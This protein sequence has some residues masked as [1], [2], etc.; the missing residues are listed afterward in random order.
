MRPKRVKLTGEAG[1]IATGATSLLFTSD[2]SKLIVGA[3]MGSSLVMVVDLKG[4][5]NDNP[6]VLRS[7]EQH[8]MRSVIIG[9]I[10]RAVKNLPASLDAS[11]GS[12]HHSGDDFLEEPSERL[13]LH[14]SNAPSVTSTITCMATS[15]DGQ[16]LA[17]GDTR[18][19]IHVFNL[20]SVQV[21]IRSFYVFFPFKSFPS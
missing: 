9:G 21:F 7:F 6:R 8:R 16:W 3:C 13:N 2:S 14:S 11:E 10:G 12:P 18:H 1:F 20:D 19:R 17:S 5:A 15:M 4:E